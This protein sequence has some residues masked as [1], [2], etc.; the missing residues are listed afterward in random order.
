M[1]NNHIDIKVGWE[2][3]NDCVH[4]VIADKRENTIK[5]NLI[6]DDIKDIIEKNKDCSMMTL[7][8]GEPTI[9]EDFIEICKLIKSL[10]IEIS[11]QTNGRKLKNVNFFNEVNKYVDIFLIAIHSY[12]KSIHDNITQ[13]NGS[14]DDTMNGIIN[15]LNV[16]RKKCVTHTVISKYNMNEIDRTI[17]FF[18]NINVGGCVITFVHAAGNAWKYFDTVVP[19][20]SDIK[21]QIEYIITKYDDVV[22][23]DIPPCYLLKNKKM[24]D[25]SIDLY[26]QQENQTKDFS[27]E[28]GGRRDDSWDMINNEMK[29]HEICKKCIIYNK[30]NGMW[31]QYIDKYNDEID[32]LPITEMTN[33]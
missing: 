14:W 2:C 1:N 11:L 4:C 25:F 28:V 27:V 24:F 8:G 9:R 12:D 32:L 19:K 22:T 29:K 13:R 21:S 3:N 30:C 10:N 18:K 5:Q 20:L 6:F 33:E 17:D 23:N 31:K 15:I 16:D 26:K 7:T